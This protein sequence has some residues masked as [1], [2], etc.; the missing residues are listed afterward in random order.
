MIKVSY[1][2]QAR[3]AQRIDATVDPVCGAIYMWETGRTATPDDMATFRVKR[4]PGQRY[5]VGKC[6]YGVGMVILRHYWMR[7]SWILTIIPL[8]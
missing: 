5:R 8:R 1:H 4:Q 7:D 3:F 6:G 2:A